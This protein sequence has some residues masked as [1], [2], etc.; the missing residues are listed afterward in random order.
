MRASTFVFAISMIF[1][2]SACSEPVQTAEWYKE[3][4]AE[5]KAMMEKCAN[6]P[7]E[8][9][10]TPNCINAQQAARMEALKTPDREIK[11]APVSW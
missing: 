2:L 1:A 4:Q 5:R 3:H 9:R 7:G 11:S 10:G 6:N 8:L